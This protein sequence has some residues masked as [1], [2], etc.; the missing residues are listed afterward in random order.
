MDPNKAFVV[1]ADREYRISIGAIAEATL[2][3]QQLPS[4]P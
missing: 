3:A 1:A 4:N 2:I